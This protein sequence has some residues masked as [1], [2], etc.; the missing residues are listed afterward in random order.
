MFSFNKLLTTT[1]VGSSL[2]LAAC[3]GSS[4]KSSASSPPASTSP[5]AS[6][7]IS[8]SGSALTIGTAS[9]SAG[10]YLTGASGRAL[11]IWVADP[12]GKSSCAGTCAK[13]WPPLT[14]G[15]MP[16]VTG[17]V[18]AADITLISRSDGTKQVAYHGRPLYYYAGDTRAGMIS[19]NGSKQFGAY[20]WLIS[21]AG[22]YVDRSSSG[23]SSNASSGG[24]S[25]SS[26][27]GG[28]G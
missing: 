14:T 17:G 16:K 27:A 20:W 5:S 18:T 24:S 10:K 8:S 25:G 1:A 21:P 28:W 26:S 7:P 15:S 4:H 22:G 6:Q 13:V 12:K 23:G 11:Y 3:G 2:L 19:G 9:V